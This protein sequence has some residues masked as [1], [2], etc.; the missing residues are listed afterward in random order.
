MDKKAAVE[1]DNSKKNM[2]ANAKLA[3]SL[4]TQERILKAALKLFNEK[5][6]DEVT[7][8]DIAAAADLSP[9]NLYYH[10]KNKKAIV[11]ELFYRI[12]I[13]SINKWWQKN[14]S[15]REVRFTDFM[16]FYF[17]SLKKYRFFFRDFSLLLKSDP[18]LAREWKSLYSRLFSVMRDT[19]D[20]WVKQGLIKPFQTNEQANIF[21][22]TVWVVASFT[23]VHLEARGQISK[24]N[25]IDESSRY[26][27]HFLYP[28]HTEKGKRVIELFL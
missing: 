21:I 16:Q 8:H 5:G 23:Q 1:T 17:G 7:T 13:F 25:Q 19:L 27:A 9:G 26:L 18:I 28:Y 20:G 2:P 14:P 4:D 22:E 10:Y 24:E 6:T 3:Q 15:H 11:R 12:D